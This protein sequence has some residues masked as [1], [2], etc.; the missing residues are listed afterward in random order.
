MEREQ[1]RGPIIQSVE[2]WLLRG[3]DSRLVFGAEVD[4][5]NKHNMLSHVISHKREEMACQMVLRP[6]TGQHDRTH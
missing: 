5:A 3:D 2:H 1:A 4:A 6:S